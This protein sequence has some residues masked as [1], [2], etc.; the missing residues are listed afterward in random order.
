MPLL[1]PTQDFTLTPIP[2][3]VSSI[4][5]PYLP[6]KPLPPFLPPLPLPSLLPPALQ[7][8][9]PVSFSLNFSSFS[10]LKYITYMVVEILHSDTYN[11]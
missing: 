5:L 6:P 11:R 2:V 10:V 7:P 4:L 3:R 9:F 8:T 1:L